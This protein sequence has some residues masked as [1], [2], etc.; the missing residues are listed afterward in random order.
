MACVWP[1]PARRESDGSVRL[2]KLRTT[3]AT[4]RL[5]GREYHDRPDVFRSDADLL[6][7]CGK[8]SGCRRAR[9]REWSLRCTLEL[10]RHKHACWATLTYDDDR[11]PPTLD[12]RH[13]SLFLRYLRRRYDAGE[14]RFFASGEYGE[15]TWRPHYHVILYGCDLADKPVIQK[16]WD[17]GFCSVD[18]LTPA[19]INYVAGYVA[20]KLGV[21]DE[22]E[23]RVDMRTGEIY[24]YQPPFVLMSRRPGIGGHFRKF[25]HSWRDHAVLDGT[26]MP[27]PRFLHESWK[28]QASDDELLALQTERLS[29]LRKVSSYGLRA[30]ELEMRTQDSYSSSKRGKL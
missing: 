12:K 6:L 18:P 15:R 11:C 23:E 16:V 19:S 27:V 1:M 17:K 10:D 14:V 2:L 7:P 26:P 20:K 24:Q 28:A 5:G 22:V 29:K 13:L 21:V 3:E 9:A 8:C 25:P 4:R 30:K